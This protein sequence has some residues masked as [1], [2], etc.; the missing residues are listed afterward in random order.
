M[1]P[2]GRHPTVEERRTNAGYNATRLVFEFPAAGGVVPSS[3]FRT[4]RPYRYAVADTPF[5]L[6]AVVAY[7][8]YFTVEELF[9][10]AYF[11][12]RYFAAF[13]NVIDLGI[14]V[15]STAP[16]FPK[17]CENRSFEPRKQSAVRLL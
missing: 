6:A 17:T 11:R 14:V 15:V 8:V 1:T 2:G 12:L 3:A 10:M 7:V 13:W 16:V 5:A 9:E 4:V